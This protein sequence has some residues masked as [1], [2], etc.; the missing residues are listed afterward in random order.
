MCIGDQAPY[1][2]EIEINLEYAAGFS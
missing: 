1:A 2:N